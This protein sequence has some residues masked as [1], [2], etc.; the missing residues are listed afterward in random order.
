MSSANTA[1]TAKVVKVHSTSTTHIQE[2]TCAGNI[3]L[4]H[5]PRSYTVLCQG[6]LPPQYVGELL[7]GIASGSRLRRYFMIIS[8]RNTEYVAW[9]S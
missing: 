3:D 1:H 9:P 4:P 2:F 6:F 5:Y 8:P 7:N